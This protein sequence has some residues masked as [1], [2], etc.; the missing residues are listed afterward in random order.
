MRRAIC[1]LDLTT[2]ADQGAVLLLIFPVFASHSFRV[3]WAYHR[4]LC[5]RFFCLE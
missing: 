1:S 2:E 4:F 3:S 5:S